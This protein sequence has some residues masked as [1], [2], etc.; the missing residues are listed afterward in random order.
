MFEE[1]TLQNLVPDPDEKQ[2]SQH[3]SGDVHGSREK[4]AIGFF[5]I[6]LRE[7]RASNDPDDLPE[8]RDSSCSETSQIYEDEEIFHHFQDWLHL[9]SFTVCGKWF[10]KSFEPPFE[11]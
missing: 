9:I 1:E 4:P 11:L 3:G 5:A 10:I 6:S 2:S 8:Y 7:L